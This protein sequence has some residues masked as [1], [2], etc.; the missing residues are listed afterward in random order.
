MK[1][2]EQIAKETLEWEMTA[3]E[4]TDTVCHNCKNA[5]QVDC[6][7]HIIDDLEAA[8]QWSCNNEVTVLEMSDGE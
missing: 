8:A 5:Y 7:N 6:D 4:V 2:L 1:S 3:Q